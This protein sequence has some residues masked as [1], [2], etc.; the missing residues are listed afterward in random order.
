[1]K[2]FTAHNATFFYAETGQAEKPPFWWA[3]G[4]GQSHGAFLPLAGSFEA[5]F[6]HHLIDFPGFGASPPPPGDW[7]TEDYAE[8]IAAHLKSTGSPPIIW[9]GHSFGARVGLQLASRYPELV[10]AV[11]FIAGA[12]LKRKRSP[13]QKFK[14]K[15]R[16]YIYKAL[17]KLAGFGL[18]DKDRLA[19]RFG[20]RDYQNAGAMRAT[21]IKVV[22][23]DLTPQAAATT[24]PALLIYGK[25][26]NETP[27]E[28]GERQKK[29]MKNAQ[30]HILDGQDHYAVLSS[31]RH[32]VAAIMDEF[33]HDLEKGQG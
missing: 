1:M 23:E 9:A 15:S 8:A 10:K 31:G 5:R 12:G 17:K 6:H 22:N 7:G 30:L 18:I 4:W 33:L 26:D 14:F 24:C 2:S 25:N 28:F 3:H 16:I 13:W 29:L 21:F 11:I 27:P 19:A 32:Q 20:S